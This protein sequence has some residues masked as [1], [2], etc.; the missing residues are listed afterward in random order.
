MGEYSRFNVTAPEALIEA[1]DQLAAA[2][3]RQRSDVIR[4][5]LLEYVRRRVATSTALARWI[6]A[7]PPERARELR[8][9]LELPDDPE[10]ELARVRAINP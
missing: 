6:A 10:E 9:L 7:Q 1:L 3:L 4:A 2:D 8:L 5:A